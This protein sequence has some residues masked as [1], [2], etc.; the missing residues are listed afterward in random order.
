LSIVYIRF[1]LDVLDTR[2]QDRPREPLLERLLACATAA[3]TCEDWREDAWQLLQPVG[4]RACS[5][6]AAGPAAVF[7]AHGPSREGYACVA[8]ALHYVAGMSNVHLP[9]GGL[10]RLGAAEADA[11][12]RDFAR[13]FAEAE[14][15]LIAGR[16]GSLACLFARAIDAAMRDPEDVLGCDIGLYL[17]QGPDG[18]R[19]RR[20]MSEIEMWLFEHPV[21]LARAARR[22]P[23]ITGLWLWDGGPTFAGLPPLPA[24]VSGR[25]ALFSAWSDERGA[26]EQGAGSGLILAEASPGTPAWRGFESGRLGRLLSDLRSGKF[27]RLELSAGQRRYSLGPQ[28][29]WRFWRRSRPWWECFA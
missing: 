29:R 3:V 18:P 8:S 12:T 25:D 26:S 7:A 5:R 15:R 4:S 23:P 17:P 6:P 11:L 21:N 24:W 16:D 13:V 27:T 10:L 22:E 28:W 2:P 20:L 9:P 14:P 1:P 19:L